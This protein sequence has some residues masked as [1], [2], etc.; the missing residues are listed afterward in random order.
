MHSEPASRRRPAPAAAGLLA[1][2]LSMSAAFAQTSEAPSA[3]VDRVAAV[4][5][6]GVIT[7]SD[8]RW[9]IRYKGYDVPAATD[10][11][12]AFLR[13]ILEQIVDQTLIAAE[14]SRT[15]GIRIE[16]EDIE[17][18]VAAYR[19]RFDTEEDF[20]EQLDRLDM[21][22]ED[23]R[24]LIQRELAVLRFVKLRFEPFVIVLPDEIQR[25]YDQELTPELRRGGQEP[26]RIGLVEEQIRQI[27]SVQQTT[28]E[29]D[30]WVQERRRTASVS[31]LLFR[32]GPLQGDLPDSLV[33]VPDWVKISGGRPPKR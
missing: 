11:R 13:T 17:R 6:G 10:S 27:L 18:Q 29:V 31:I 12:D 5:E 28:E 26:P 15:P 2:F 16:A 8:L 21:D 19:E 25:Y 1:V 3:V 30:R 7:L 22:A 9:L 23:L 24:D 4:A 20:Q 14:A 33:S 32:S